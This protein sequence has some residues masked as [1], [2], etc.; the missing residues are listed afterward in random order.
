MTNELVLSPIP[1]AEL[2]RDIAQVV[3]EEISAHHAAPAEPEQLL[4]RKDAARLLGITL[5]TLRAY[6]R[7]GLLKGYR[8][9]SRVRYKRSEVIN[10]LAPIRTRNTARP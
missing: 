8:I 10:G 6:T 7:S 9:G 2:V 4:T 1:R 3:R 5:P